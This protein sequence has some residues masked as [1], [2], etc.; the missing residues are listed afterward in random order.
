MSIQLSCCI[1][2]NAYQR[3]N[4]TSKKIDLFQSYDV[5]T[6]GQL[7]DHCEEIILAPNEILFKESSHE[8]A[9]YLILLGEVEIYKGPKQIALIGEMSLLESKERSASAKAVKSS[10]LLQINKGQF[11]TY[12]ATEQEALLP[13]MRTLSGRIRVDLANM[14]DEMRKLSMFTHDIKNNLSPLSMTEGMLEE[15]IAVFRGKEGEKPREGLEDM[16]D[17]FDALSTVRD[18][19]MT[20][21][22][23]S[24]NHV[25]R[26]K[27][28]YIK[29]KQDILP[30]I[31][32]TVKG[33]STH[34]YMVGKKS[35]F[36]PRATTSVQVSTR[37]ILRECSRI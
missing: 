4:R 24:L 12:L 25:K 2:K 37:L 9:M 35:I 16:E 27:V 13:M 6:L 31:R 11:D 22:E 18:N 23:A 33:I 17:C 29:T 21:I 36:N 26:V 7:I 19:L 1:P 14:M 15:M 20:L 34:K 3:Q 8:T 30:I 28:P 5:N 10:T 32:E